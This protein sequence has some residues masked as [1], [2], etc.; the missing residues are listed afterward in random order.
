M[1][2]FEGRQMRKHGVHQSWIASGIIALGGL[3]TTSHV[4]AQIAA[5][6]TLSTNV[7][8]TDNRNFTITNGNRAGSNLFHSFSEF[9]VPTGGSAFFNNGPEIQNIITRVTGSSISNIDGL[10]KANGAANLFL[11]NPNGIIFGPHAS[12]SIGGSI[13][14]S[15]ARSLNFADGTQFSATA[16][17]TTPLLTISVPIGLQFGE[18]AGGVRVQGSELAVQPGK[19]LALVGGDKLMLL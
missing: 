11:L 2:G 7:K 4:Q 17:P 14:A 10:I 9:S 3:V 12:L 15:T 19:T 16:H 13:L 5:D 1:V 18:T 8:T 6:G